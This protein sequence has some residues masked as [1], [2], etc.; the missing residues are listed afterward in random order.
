MEIQEKLP[1]LNAFFDTDLSGVAYKDQNRKR[2]IIAHLSLKTE[3]TLTELSELLN[4]SVPKAT[5]LM[6]LL[7]DDGLVKVAGRRSEGPGRKASVYTLA[8]NAFYFLG[9][10]TRRY[11]INVGLMGFDKKMVYQEKNIPFLYDNADDSLSTIINLLYDFIEKS[12]IP[13]EKIAGMGFSISGRVNIHTGKIITFYHFGEASIKEVLEKEFGIP[14]FLDNDSRTLAYGEFHFGKRTEENEV[15]ILN[16]DYGLALGIF[17]GGK[18]V[19]GVSGYAGELGHIPLFDNEKICYCGKKGCLETEA[20]GRALIE[21]ITMELEKGSSSFLGPIFEAKQ[22]LELEDIVE[23]IQRGDNLAITAVDRIAS[24]LGRGLAVSINLFNPQLIIIGGCL[25][26]LGDALLLPVKSFILRHS[27]SV[28]NSDT[29]V[30]LSEIG[31]K[32]G[33]LGSCLLVRDKILGLV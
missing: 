21:I 29:R 28:V 32:A 27:L 13:L 10:E 25:S 7:E 15:L 26:A 4:I 6:A 12:K 20:S 9:I 8:P 14:V 31:A 18:P 30:E 5:E 11:S 23:A 1:H 22:R 3:A 19:Y 33:L 2:R 24:Q 17:V 16:L